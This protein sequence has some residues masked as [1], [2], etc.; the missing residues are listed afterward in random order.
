M[1]TRLLLLALMA[2]CDGPISQ[3]PAPLWAAPLSA[4]RTA[5]FAALQAGDY[6]GLPSVITSLTSEH[7]AG[8]R[9]STAVL[10]FAHAWRL[11]H[12]RDRVV[13][14]GERAVAFP[15]GHRASP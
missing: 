13:D 7:L 10:G 5:F 1:R 9:T 6:A 15:R 8:D 3:A 14:R 11:A 2:G 4:G 12:V